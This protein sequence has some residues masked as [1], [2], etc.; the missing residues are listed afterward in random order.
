MITSVLVYHIAV[1]RQKAQPSFN[2]PNL[3]KKEGWV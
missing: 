3:P 2:K 1:N